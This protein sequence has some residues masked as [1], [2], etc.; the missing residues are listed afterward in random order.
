MENNEINE[1]ILKNFNNGALSFM[2][3]S[4]INKLTTKEWFAGF[5]I[6]KLGKYAGLKRAETNP[7]GVALL[8]SQTIINTVDLEDQYNR[9]CLE[10]KQDL[11]EEKEAS[12]YDS[13]GLLKPE[14]ALTESQKK[15][16]MFPKD[17]IK[18]SI[19]NK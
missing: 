17:K 4:R 13:K 11:E 14:A 15:E 9:A 8:T 18:K 1:E 3:Q 16:M 12:N 2:K 10:I 19:K 6:Y 5:G 7:L